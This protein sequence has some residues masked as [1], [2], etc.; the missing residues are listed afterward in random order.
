MKIFV[1]KIILLGLKFSTGNFLHEFYWCS[2]LIITIIDIQS[3]YIGNAVS[4][5]KDAHTMRNRA[6]EENGSGMC[7]G[8]GGQVNEQ[9]NEWVMGENGKANETENR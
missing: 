7:E 4:V 9:D 8:G 6:E 1:F 5:E 3:S 2:L